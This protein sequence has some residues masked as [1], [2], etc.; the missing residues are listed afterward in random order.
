MSQDNPVVVDV[1]PIPPREK[2]P[3]IFG[4]FD[5]LASGESL[6]LVNDH[7]PTPLLYQFQAER[8]GQFTWTALEEGPVEWRISIGK[9]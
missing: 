3:A 9:N 2:H 4:T 7:S 5:G 6:I 1:R 8:P